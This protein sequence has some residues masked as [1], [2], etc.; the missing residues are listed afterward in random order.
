MIDIAAQIATVQGQLDQEIAQAIADLKA[1]VNAA[2]D[3]VRDLSKQKDDAEKHEFELLA[4]KTDYSSARDPAR[5]GQEQLHE[6]FGP[7]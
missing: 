7:G 2:A 4:P 3:K 1:D 5:R 6:H